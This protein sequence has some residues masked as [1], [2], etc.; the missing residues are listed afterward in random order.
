MADAGLTVNSAIS[1]NGTATG[2][3]S[4]WSTG[5]NTI[6]LLPSTSTAVA[7]PPPAV[8]AVGSPVY[9]LECVTYQI[10]RPPDANNV[11]GGTAP[12]LV[13]GV[14]AGLDCNIPGSPCGPVVDGIDDLQLAYACDGCVSTINGGIPD[15]IID[16]RNGSNSFDSGDFITDSAWAT[17]P[18]VPSSIRLIQITVVARQSTQDRGN[19]ELVRPMISAGPVQVSDHNPIQD[20]AYYNSAT[21]PTYRRRT[22][23]RTVET[24]NIGQ[25]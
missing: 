9:L 7:V 23:T 22:L 11:C 1:L 24:R 4:A 14:T 8:F 16:D 2:I 17:A 13:R 18:L 10:I 15:R 20:G 5:G 21:Y 19:S 12:C 3:V 6:T 25:S